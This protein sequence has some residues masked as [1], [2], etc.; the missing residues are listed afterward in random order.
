MNQCQLSQLS[1]CLDEG[2]ESLHLH[3]LEQGGRP[4]SAAAGVGWSVAGEVSPTDS[5]FWLL[6]ALSLSSRQMQTKQRALPPR[7]YARMY[8]RSGMCV[9]A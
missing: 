9:P 8:P 2:L 7:I 6:R 3:Q 1:A 5:G 4:G